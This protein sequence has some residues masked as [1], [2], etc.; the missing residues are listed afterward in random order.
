MCGATRIVAYYKNK[1]NIQLPYKEK[2][3]AVKYVI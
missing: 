1:P 2:Y 3:I